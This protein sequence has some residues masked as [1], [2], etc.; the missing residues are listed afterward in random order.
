MID[1]IP[2]ID[3]NVRIDIVINPKTKQPK[4]IVDGRFI[5]NTEDIDTLIQELE[6]KIQREEITY[7]ESKRKMELYKSEL[8]RL[9]DLRDMKG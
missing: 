5:M 3:N 4:Y 9:R 2:K 7:N 6:N 1:Y 8:K